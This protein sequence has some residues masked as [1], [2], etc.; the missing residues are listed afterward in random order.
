MG[1]PFIKTTMQ[2]ESKYPL[3]IITINLNN[4]DGL[5]KTIE[6]VVN[7]TYRD[8][9]YIVIDGASTDG[10]V[11]IIQHYADKISYW[12]SEPDTGIYNAMNKG[13]RVAQGEYL[14]FLNSGDWLYDY[15]V[16][17]NVLPFF[18]KKKSIYT[19][20]IVNKSEYIE[21]IIQHPEKISFVYLMG[22]GLAHQSSFIKKDL[23]INNG[24]FDETLTIV[25][26]WAFLFLNIGIYGESYSRIPIIISVF[27]LSG[28]SSDEKNRKG[29]FEDK[30]K[31][32]EK[33][34]PILLIEDLYEIKKL[35]NRIGEKNINTIIDITSGSKSKWIFNHLLNLMSTL[36]R[37]K[38]KLFKTR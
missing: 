1:P 15:F 38:N 5:E 25:A 10:S 19:G 33:H 12:V 23:F 3:T 9:E 8:F 2:A 37:L 27:D 32:F 35:K 11:D 28:I 24:L 7:Q 16:V 14:L 22:R 29:A 21:E 20:D 13:I 30:K 26:D 17:S 18:L 4:R 36:I 34:L 6:S 31:V